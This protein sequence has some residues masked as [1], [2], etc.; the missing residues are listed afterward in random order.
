MRTLLRPALLALVVA[1]L[2]R[3]DG[4]LGVAAALAALAAISWWYPAFLLK[5]VEVGRTHPGRVFH[6]E[7]VEIAYTA[8]NAGKVSVPWISVAD[9][10]PFDLGVSTSR[11]VIALGPGEQGRMVRKVEANRRG[12]YRIG[13]ATVAS[14]D[15]FGM[16]R[17]EGPRITASQLIVYPRIVPLTELGIPAN[18]PL[19]VIPT[20]VP[21]FP[22]PTRMI[23]VRSYAPGDRYRDI[24][25]KAS[26]SHGELL[27]KQFQPGVDRDVVVALDLALEAHPYPGRRRSVELA[28]TV[29]ASIV[30]HMVTS[31][32]Q[33]VGLRVVAV[34][35][36]TGNLSRVSLSPH[37]DQAHLMEVLETLARSGPTSTPD[38]SFLIDDSGLGYGSSLVFVTGLV[39]ARRMAAL[40]RAR[41]QGPAVSAIVT[42]RDPDPGVV[43]GL[44]ESGVAVSV[45]ASHLDLV[46]T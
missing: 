26:A 7:T 17:V 31:L 3:V 20:R 44:E 29:A 45:I 46:G 28:V 43:S 1:L 24:H 40:I 5:S 10:I 34:D 33:S 42:G 6:G 13:P 18:S 35:T 2:I 39:D 22:D 11:W 38:P 15:F 4:A 12:V 32:R 16:R 19:P 27:T 9:P 8:H 14:G 25:W 30:H 23:G 41:R 36:P 21:L 37:P